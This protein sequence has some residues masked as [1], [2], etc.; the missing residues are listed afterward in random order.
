M[1]AI[2]QSLTFGTNN[3][4]TLGPCPLGS[5]WTVLVSVPKAT[6]SSSFEV[7]LQG[8]QLGSMQ[9]TATFGPFQMRGNEVLTIVSTG[10]AVTAAQTVTVMGQADSERNAPTGIFPVVSGGV[11]TTAGVVTPVFL[12]TPPTY[13]APSPAVTYALPGDATALAAID[14]TNIT[15]QPFAAPSSGRALIHVELFLGGSNQGVNV[16]LFRH[17][18]TTQ[19]GNTVYLLGYYGLMTADFLIIGL[20]PG[21]T[22]QFDVAACCVTSGGSSVVAWGATGATGASYGAPAVV[23]V[24]A[25]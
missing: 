3:K 23:T 21:S 8:T 7:Y 5:V 11:V 10:A 1:A 9:G 22:Y 4:A 6:N 20:D 25:A 17:G 12:I 16:G 19:V 14:T 13:Y 24:Q 15:T 2:L 18:T